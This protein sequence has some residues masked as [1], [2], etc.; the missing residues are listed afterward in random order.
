LNFEYKKIA[1]DDN[2]KTI[3]FI[4][5]ACNKTKEAEPVEIHFLSIFSPDEPR[6]QVYLDAAANFHKLNP[7]INIKFDGYNMKED[8][9]G[10][11]II[12]AQ[13]TKNQLESSAPPD[14]VSLSTGAL[15]DFGSKSLLLDLK[16]LNV[17]PDI[18]SNL[19]EAATENG[20]LLVLP[21]AMNPQVVIYN[22]DIFDK[23]HLPYPQGTW[24]WEQFKTISQKLDST[25]GS[26]LPYDISTLSLLMASTGKGF[27][28]H[29]GETSVGYLDSPEAVRSIQWMNHLYR[30]EGKSTT[31]DFG[32]LYNNFSNFQIGM[33]IFPYSQFQVFLNVM[34]DRGDRIGVAPLPYFEGGKPTNSAFLEGYG[35]SKKSKHPQEAWEFIKYLALTNQEVTSKLTDRYLSTSKAIAEATGQ[36]T[37]PNKS[38][39]IGELDHVVKPSGTANPFFFSALFGKLAAQFQSLLTTDDKDIQAKL[40]EIALQLDLEMNRLKTAAD[41]QT[42]SSAP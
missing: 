9:N 13:D 1:S 36:S 8:A 42:E 15:P 19:L 2:N 6:L 22:K 38:V 28:S 35:I 4:A 18:N 29:D 33:V 17:S 21:Y 5:T 25:N 11:I 20:Q 10:N 26:A 3:S 30:D 39:A 14:I 16:L 7:L 34:G 23:A 27:F 32:T 37:D 40:H 41:Q 12:G 31:M 24:T